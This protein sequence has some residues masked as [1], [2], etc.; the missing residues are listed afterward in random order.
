MFDHQ[1]RAINLLTRLGWETRIAATE[2][3]LDFSQGDLRAV[4]EETVDYLLFVDEAPLAAPVSGVSAFSN[5]FAMTGPKDRSGRSL[6]QLD[7]R[8]RLFRYRC[9]YMIYSPAF[10]ALPVEARS[11]V[12]TRINARLTDRDT[13][14]ILDETKPGWR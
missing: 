9:S 4:L 12:L 1:G 11:A 7:L 2:G 5:T 3:R 8:S 6:R 13:I 10:D 14:A